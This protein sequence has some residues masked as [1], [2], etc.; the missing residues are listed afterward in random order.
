MKF[1]YGFLLGSNPPG[2]EKSFEDI[3]DE[4]IRIAQIAEESGFD[5]VWSAEHHF[6]EDGTLPAPLTLSAGL[7]T[8]T[9]SIEIGIG[10]LVA[11][12]YHPLHI[13]EQAAVVDLLSG[14][15]FTLGIANGYVQK[16]FDAFDVSIRKR[17][18]R[19]EDTIRTCRRAW[20]GEE[21]SLDGHVI[22]F[23]DITVR[24]TP[25]QPDGPDIILGGTSDPAVDR[26]ADMTDG[27][28]GLVNFPESLSDVHTH[29][30]FL[31]NVDRIERRRGFDGFR[32]I[33]HQHT[34]VGTSDN[35]ARET[36]GDPSIFY[37]REYLRN[38]SDRDAEELSDE[39]EEEL[40][41]ADIVGGPETVVEELKEYERQLPCELHFIARMW[42]PEMSF[43][44]KAAA[45]RQFGDEVIPE[46]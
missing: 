26:S 14:G 2:S 42:M 10:A 36:F 41:Q 1:G 5:S 11:P 23:D 24:P 37:R 29:S 20:T 17:A 28:I 13:A 31:E 3:Y 32:L 12:L 22:S 34:F 9:S 44:E 21:F 7:A 27:H 16:E 33:L 6:Y 35:H 15:R 43:S 45:I 18:P 38:A 19:V 39:T 25:A 4:S 30:Q 8:A 40:W 46:F